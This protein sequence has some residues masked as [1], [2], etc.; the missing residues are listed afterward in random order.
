MVA[1]TRGGAANPMKTSPTISRTS[2]FLSLKAARALGWNIA[3]M[4]TLFKIGVESP[5][6]NYAST[7]PF[8]TARTVCL[9]PAEC[10]N[11]LPVDVFAATMRESELT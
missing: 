4:E 7:G 9:P 2:R 11:K 8:S 1:R 3:R 10:L 5:S 6:K